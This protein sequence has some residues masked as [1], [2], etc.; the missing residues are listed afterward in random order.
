MQFLFATALWALPLVGLPILLHLLFRRKSPVVM[1]STIRFIK[2]SVQHTAARKRVQRWLLLASRAIALLLLVVVAAQP[3]KMLASG[4]TGGR[5]AEAAI[6]ID[7]SYSMLLKDQKITLLSRADGMAQELLRGQLKNAKVAIFASE[8]A[9]ANIPEHLLPASDWLS[10]WS[11]LRPQ[12]N[13]QPLADRVTAA[14]ELLKSQPADDKWLVVISDFQKKEFPPQFAAFP[15]AHVLLLDLHPA[16]PASAGITRVAIDPPQPTPGIGSDV[17]VDVVGPPQSARPLTI[18]ILTTEDGKLLETPTQM[19][20]IDAG[21]HARLRFPI[22]LPS[23]HWML[24]RAAFSDDDDMA[25]DNMRD[26]LVEVPPRQIVDVLNDPLQPDAQ[27]FVRLALDPMQGKSDAWPLIVRETDQIAPDANVAVMMLDTW[28]DSQRIGQ[29]VK[30]VRGGGT[31]IWFI[32]PGL[33]QTWLSLPSE[34]QT[35][36]EEL[37]PSAPL[38]AESSDDSPHTLGV[39]SLQEPLLA[40]LADKRFGIDSISVLRLVPFAVADESATPLLVAYPADPRS[41]TR[42]HG[43]LY[44][45]SVESGSVYTFATLP[46]RQYTNLPTHPLFL[47]L[48]VRMSLHSPDASAATNIEIGQPIVLTGKL[49]DGLSELRIVDPQGAV[50]AVFPSRLT[51]GSP[52]FVFNSTDA[53]GLYRWHKPNDDATLALANVQLPSSESELVYARPDDVIEPSDNVISAHSVQDLQ[54]HFAKLSEPEP[55]WSGALAALLL[56]LCA[57]AFM[58]SIAKLRKP[59]SPNALVQIS[60][61]H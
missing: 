19:A 21:G 33:E 8:P 11:P 9:A 34:Q 59:P 15:E 38:P 49:I 18:S 56:L 6:V 24:L 35:Q 14:I 22:H 2:A 53:P 43:L 25:W 36:L 40:G 39:A 46:D 41:G 4:W 12:P 5:S 52:A 37:L 45:R 44:R 26:Q 27:R 31:L 61:R 13:P 29:L 30:F 28:P 16:D 60:S 47:P 1:F 3:A 57:E 50:S 58:A 54:T 32:R 20:A 51:D 7:T 23:Q 42:S 55:H 17:V 10:Q 48:L